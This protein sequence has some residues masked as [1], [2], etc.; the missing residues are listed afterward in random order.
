MLL[1]LLPILLNVQIYPY[2]ELLVSNFT[3]PP[4]VERMTVEVGICYTKIFLC[5]PA[6]I[7]TF[8]TELQL[9]SEFRDINCN[10]S[11]PSTVLLHSSK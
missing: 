9:G 8:I 5:C 2:E 10:D 11:V 1:Y 6:E 3:L 7:Q 4:G